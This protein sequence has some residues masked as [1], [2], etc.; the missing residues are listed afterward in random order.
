MKKIVIQK[1]SARNLL[2]SSRSKSSSTTFSVVQAFQL[3][4]L[5]V[6]DFLANQLGNSIASSHLQILTAMIEQNNSHV[7]SEK[8]KIV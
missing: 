8:Q 6:S 1:V 7:S 5:G 3:L 4:E 2:G